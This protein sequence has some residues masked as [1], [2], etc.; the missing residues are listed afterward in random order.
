[1]NGSLLRVERERPLGRI[2]RARTTPNASGPTSRQNPRA[3]SYRKVTALDSEESRQRKPDGG[4][5]GDIPCMRRSCRD[6]TIENRGGDRTSPCPRDGR[7]ADGCPSRLSH[8]IRWVI[9][10]RSPFPVF[11]LWSACGQL[12]ITRRE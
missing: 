4:S 6:F 2:T 11:K 7:P 3:R 8:P 10:R 12:T 5:A 9:D 1:M